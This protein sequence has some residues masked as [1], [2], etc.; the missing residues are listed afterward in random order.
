MLIHVSLHPV[1]LKGVVSTNYPAT[2]EPHGLQRPKST[3]A[4]IAR[5]R[6][7]LVALSTRLSVFVNVPS[8][9]ERL[10]QLTRCGRLSFKPPLKMSRHMP[11]P[12]NLVLKR[13]RSVSSVSMMFQS[14]PEKL[15]H[16]TRCGWLLFAPPLK[17]SRHML[18]P[19][20]SVDKRKVPSPLPTN[21]QNWPETS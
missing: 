17:M 9:P 15:P 4:L 7:Y 21:L 10:A 8:W 2:T 16:L 13:T 1:A 6:C 14:C 20:N 12:R 11:E 19:R 18:G 5:S 3:N